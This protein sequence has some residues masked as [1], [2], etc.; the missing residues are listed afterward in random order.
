MTLFSQYLNN[1]S[2]SFIGPFK[3]L[4]QWD[5]KAGYILSV[6]EY[7]RV[8]VNCSTNLCDATVLLMLGDKII[9]RSTPFNT[10]LERAGNRLSF[11][12]NITHHS[13]KI[14]CEARAQDKVLKSK[15]ALLIIKKGYYLIQPFIVPFC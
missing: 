13:E 12:A 14:W 15:K 3:F 7:D 4:V 6:H 1:Y 9:S 8:T 11:T 2:T 10:T 5:L